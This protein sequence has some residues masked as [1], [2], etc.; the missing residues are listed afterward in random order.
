[1]FATSTADATET[2]GGCPVVHC[3]SDHPE[4]LKDLLTCMMPLSTVNDAWGECDALRGYRG[5][6]ERLAQA[7]EVCKM[8]IK[9]L[10]DREAR[11]R[12]RVWMLLPGM[13][14]MTC[15]D[16]SFNDGDECLEEPPS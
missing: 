5:L 13:F 1:M 10:L 14:G 2:S 16:C 12:K 7:F 15:Q 6:V 3:V 8:Y 9:T 11:E 4:D